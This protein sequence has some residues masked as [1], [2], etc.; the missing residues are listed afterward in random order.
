MQPRSLAHLSDGTLRNRL[1]ALV[2]DDRVTTAELL[3]HLAE[4][5]TRRLHAK[6]GYPSL[7]AYC[8]QRL[9]FSED[10]AFKR[11]RVARAA[12]SFP[13]LLEAIAEGRLHLTGAVLLAPCLK[14]ESWEALIAAATHKTKAEIELLLAH[15]F[16]QEDVPT[17]VRAI[18][19]A[20]PPGVAAPVQ[21]VPEPVDQSSNHAGAAAVAAAVSTPEVV[22]QPPPGRTQP[23]RVAPL[24]PGRYVFRTTIGQSAHDK[25]RRLQDLLGAQ[26]PSGDVAQV[27]ERAFDALIE[28]LEKA[29]HAATDRPRRASRR[30][31]DPRHIP[32]DVKRRVWARDRGRCTFVSD[33][34]QRCSATESLE[35]DHIQEV[36]RG[37]VA[38]V[39][40]IRLLCRAHNQY[41]AERTFGVEFMRARRQAAR[42]RVEESS[43]SISPHPG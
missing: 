30:S 24:A 4:F 16:P 12:R 41:M 14:P 6:D 33:S 22:P 37:G 9:H 15:R 3:R 13:A 39:G 25:L 10:M 8:V 35:Y 40:N 32:A 26:V 20:P 5:E 36:A 27:L 31:V 7:F 23:A 11:I 2:D 29:K 18:P 43:V 42:S 1:A 28:K 17:L 34:G 38:S 21:V 19:D